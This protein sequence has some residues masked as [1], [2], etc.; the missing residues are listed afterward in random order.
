M[1]LGVLPGNL[2]VT[3]PHGRRAV[4][5]FVT[6]THTSVLCLMAI[7]IIKM[8][9]WLIGEVRHRRVCTVLTVIS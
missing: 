8:L 2:K 1:S 9:L 5:G 3:S 4:H 6:A 7:R